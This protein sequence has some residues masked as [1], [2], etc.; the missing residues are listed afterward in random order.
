A[1]AEAG[2]VSAGYIVLRL[3][4]AVK[5][6]FADWLEQHY[7][8]HRKKV[9]DRL[10]DIRGGKLNDAR[11]K[12]RMRGE[13]IFAEQIKK[14]FEVAR[15]RAGLNARGESLTLSTEAFRRRTKNQMELFDE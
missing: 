4:Y 11:F 9:L 13:G 1:G 6:L 3:P 5:D 15:N 10:K 7:P 12:T 8:G 2:A 14:I